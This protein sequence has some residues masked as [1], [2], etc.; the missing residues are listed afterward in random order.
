MKSRAYLAVVGVAVFAALA[1][2]QVAFAQTILPPI[3][4]SININYATPAPTIL[5][6]GANIGSVG[7][8]SLSI[9]IFDH[10]YTVDAAAANVLSASWTPISLSSF[11]ADS[12]V[13]VWGTLDLHDANVI[14]G[15]NIRNPLP[16]FSIS[17][18]PPVSFPT[19]AVSTVDTAAVQSSLK[20]LQDAIRA[21]QLRLAQ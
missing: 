11:T 10:T 21:L 13:N 3:G 15:I 16:Q 12:I 6:R 14:H 19:S 5:I 4:Q 18:T 8:A 9:E 1:A 7:P 2:A 20:V 17:P